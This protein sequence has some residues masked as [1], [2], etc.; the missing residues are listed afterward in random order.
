MSLGK[1]SLCID[2]VSSEPQKDAEGFVTSG[3]SVLATVRAYKEDRRGDSRWANMAAF[4]TATS[5]FRFRKPPGLTV[6]TSHTIVCNGGR[7]KITSVEDK[8]ERGMYIEV[9]AEKL[10]GAVK[11]W[12][13]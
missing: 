9:Y 13:A 5:L 2:I 3:D 7:Y 1:M 8:R 12:Q 4:S 10:E 11:Q 6:E